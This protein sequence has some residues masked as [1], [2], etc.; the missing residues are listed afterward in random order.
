MIE[1]YKLLTDNY[2][3]RNGLQSLQFSSN[4]CTRGNDIRLVYKL[5]KTQEP[6]YI[7]HQ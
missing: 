2:D 6:R 3:N 7:W 1:T 5:V 4:D